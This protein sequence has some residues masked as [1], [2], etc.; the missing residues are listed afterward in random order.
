MY[1]LLSLWIG[2]TEKDTDIENAKLENCTDG[3][4]N[5][6]DGFQDCTDDDCIGSEPACDQQNC[7]LTDCDSNLNLGGSQSIDMILIPAGDDPLG[8]YNLSNDFY[9]MTTE[10]TQGMFAE[11]MSYNFYDEYS[12]SYGS[13]DDYPAYYVN[14]HMAADFANKV[15]E[16]HNSLF[17]TDF[18]S[19]YYCT[20]SDSLSASCA[21]AGDPYQCSGYRLPTEAEWEYSAR[22]GTT[23]EFWTGE[24]EELGGTYSADHCSSTVTI[25]D[26]LNNPLLS[27]YVWF[28]YTSSSQIIAQKLPN[29]FG[30]YD[31]Q[32]NVWEWMADWYGCEFPESENNPYCST[33]DSNR[34]GKGGSWSI[35]PD[36]TRASGRY[37]SVTT[38]RDNS[39]G[40]RLGR[41][42][43]F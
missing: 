1:F 14:W 22:S 6:G 39:L 30:L 37:Y 8:R 28:C 24:G 31:M 27:D 11:I 36:Y 34:V 25:Q 4:D 35:F 21:D 12:A 40:F 38:R 41:L 16:K 10:V 17:G 32:G 23:S 5:D 7:A 33:G 20:E 43:S 19:C 2:C 29:A 42:P 9:L 3:L 18:Q 15:T 26:G 13:G